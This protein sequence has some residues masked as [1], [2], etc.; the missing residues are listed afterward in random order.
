MGKIKDLDILYKNIRA[1]VIK[2][3]QF[4]DYTSHNFTS[5]L[6]R[7]AVDYGKKQD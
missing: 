2:Y 1:L 6:F 5:D 4:P 7:L 3:D